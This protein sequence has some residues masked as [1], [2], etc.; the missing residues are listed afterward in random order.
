MTRIHL[1]LLPVF[2]LVATGAG[3]AA[4]EC[5][6]DRIELRG[7][8]GR[9]AF[10]VEVADTMESRSR[11]LMYRERLARGAGM[12]FVYERPQRVFFWMKNTLIPLDMIFMDAR[13]V[14]TRV[15]ENARPRD[16]T[17]VDGG[18]GVRFVLEI[19]GGL[20]RQLGIGPGS[21][22]RHPAIGDDKAA[23]PCEPG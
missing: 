5:R 18:E 20:A 21:E 1:L 4:G 6:A 11:G 16:E 23:W 9:A 12:L 22:A 10:S 17:P 19:N 8:W 15:H 14:V 7:D 3:A 2:L 13:G